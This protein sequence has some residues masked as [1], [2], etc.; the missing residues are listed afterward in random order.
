VLAFNWGQYRG[1]WKW[2]DEDGK[3]KEKKEY[4]WGVETSGK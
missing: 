4:S 1:E 3:L 2:Y